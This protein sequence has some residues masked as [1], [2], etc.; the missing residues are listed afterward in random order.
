MPRFVILEH[1]WKGIHWDFMLERGAALETWA[2]DSSI[3]FRV[4]LSSRKLPD[5]R[6]VYLD[7]EGEISGGRGEV[8][9]YDRGTF[10]CLIWTENLI[11]IHLR[12]G[13]FLGDVELRA[14]ENQP[15]REG[16]HTAWV[17]RF[18]ESV[19]Y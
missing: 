18:E 12:G 17:I 15:D 1:H 3:Q 10:D 19:G 4:D 5:H 16:G 11:R 9:R 14:V 8:S 2:I 7:Y 6:L 13:R